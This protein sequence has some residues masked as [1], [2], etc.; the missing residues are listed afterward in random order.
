METDKSGKILFVQ[1]LLHGGAVTSMTL[2]IDGRYGEGGGQILRTTLALSAL[3]RRPVEIHHI[4][5]GRKYGAL[6]MIDGHSIQDPLFREISTL[7]PL[8]AISDVNILSGGFNAEYGQA[9]SGV[10]NLSTKEGKEKTEGFFKVY[11]D[12][13]GIKL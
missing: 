3:L 11:T 6:Y 5:G 1:A 12:N 4:R 13:L 8:S 10:V 2:E 9:M 7:V